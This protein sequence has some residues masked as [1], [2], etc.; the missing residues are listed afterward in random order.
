ML[1]GFLITLGAGVN[2]E[3]RQVGSFCWQVIQEGRV[4][5][6][7][8]EELEEEEEEEGGWDGSMGRE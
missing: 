4:E 2:L 3:E 8:E 7:L 1:E 5:E 6:R